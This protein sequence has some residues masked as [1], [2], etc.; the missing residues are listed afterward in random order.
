MIEEVR[1]ASKTGSRNS[2]LEKATENET[3]SNQT[4]NFERAI[5]DEIK[6][7]NYKISDNVHLRADKNITMALA[8]QKTSFENKNVFFLYPKV[9]GHKDV[10]SFLEKIGLKQYFQ[11]FIENGFD[12][13]EIIKGNKNLKRRDF[14]NN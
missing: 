8:M 2:I 14:Y 5:E 13:I 4:N 10:S 1:T 6:M 3:K 9:D 11:I 7:K 12:D